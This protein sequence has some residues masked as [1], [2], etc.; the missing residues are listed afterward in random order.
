MKSQQLIMRVIKMSLFELL[1]SKASTMFLL[2][3]E[4]VQIIRFYTRTA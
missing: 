2:R 4:H 1:V 3:T